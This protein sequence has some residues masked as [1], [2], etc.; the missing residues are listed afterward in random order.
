MPR[1]LYALLHR[2]LAHQMFRFAL[3]GVA[4]LAADVVTLH[5][6]MR[7]V[8]ANPYIARGASF[9]VAATT[10][11]AL[12]RAFTFR[13]HHRGSIVG[14][15]ARFIAAN[16]FGGLINYGVFASLVATTALFAD[17][18]V[19]AIGVGSLVGM[20]FNFSASKRLVFKFQD[21][22]TVDGHPVQSSSAI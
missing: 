6:F 11:W 22:A 2:L 14:Q 19:L 13:G 15:W 18:P 20:V 9:L 7:W 10:T 16:A 8:I 21:K 12:N 4:G 5:L 3:V 1:I 17:Q